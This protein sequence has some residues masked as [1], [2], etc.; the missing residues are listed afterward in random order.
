[1][2]L[3]LLVCEPESVV[4]LKVRHLRSATVR[5]G[6]HGL[7]L[8]QNATSH[9]L[10]VDGVILRIIR[11]DLDRFFKCSANACRRMLSPYSVDCP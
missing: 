2:E 10:H 7:L 6:F 8:G 4:V 1:M 11:E 3:V 9:G 5:R